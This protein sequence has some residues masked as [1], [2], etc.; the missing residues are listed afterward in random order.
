MTERFEVDPTLAIQVRD[1]KEHLMTL[2]K[3]ELI[4]AQA[5][6]ESAIICPD[7]RALPKF[8]EG[9]DREAIVRAKIELAETYRSRVLGR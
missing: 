9:K 3:D 4:A 8:L 6:M 1:I 7:E 5:A 2:G